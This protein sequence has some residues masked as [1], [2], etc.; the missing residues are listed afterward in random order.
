[1]EKAILTAP[2]GFVKGE[3]QPF[4]SVVDGSVI[5]T[6]RELNEHN[7]RNNVVCLSD[8]YSEEVIKSGNFG[9]KKSH[10]EAK[11][12]KEDMIQSIQKLNDG[13]KPKLEVQE[14]E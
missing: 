10:D 14:N 7:I 12:I 1:M 13:Y 9:K 6:Q 5:S 4:K 2:S 3:I 11:N 8:G